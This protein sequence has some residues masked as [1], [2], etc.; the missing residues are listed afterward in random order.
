MFNTVGSGAGGGA[1]AR[2]LAE[3][4]KFN[5]LVIE[6][7]GLPKPGHDIPAYTSRFLGDPDV[8]FKYQSIP[9]PNAALYK[10][11]VSF[12]RNLIINQLY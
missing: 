9:Q 11:G 3:I 6:A 1:I 8:N 12:L 7:G 4:G 2:R 10:N 5:V